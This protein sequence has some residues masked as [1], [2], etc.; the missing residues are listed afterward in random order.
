M[1]KARMWFLLD[2]LLHDPTTQVRRQMQ[3]EAR[4]V[5]GLDGVHVVGRMLQRLWMYDTFQLLQSLIDHEAA[6]EDLKEQLEAV[7]ACILERG[8][9]EESGVMS[10]IKEGLLIV[11]T[12]CDASVRR[13][14]LMACRSLADTMDLLDSANFAPF[15][16]AP[17]TAGTALRIKLRGGTRVLF[18]TDA[19]R[20][21]TDCPCCG[22]MGGFLVSHLFRDCTAF[23]EARVTAMVAVHKRMGVLGVKTAPWGGSAVSAD[24]AASDGEPVDEKEKRML[25]YRL[26]VGASVP[27]DFV[28]LDLE[29][30]THHA[31]SRKERYCKRQAHQIDA[32]A[33]V[34]E[35]SYPFLKQVC[36]FT[37]TKLVEDWGGTL[38]E[39]HTDRYIAMAKKKK[40]HV[41]V[42]EVEV[43]HADEGVV[44]GGMVDDGD[45]MKHEDGGKETETDDENGEDC[46]LGVDEWVEWEEEGAHGGAGRSEEW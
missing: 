8:D 36:E 9:W 5:L 42:G 46:H 2:T 1:T 29:R 35:L 30:E 28:D 6:T 15:L 40:K 32:Y 21:V 25:W 3:A 16:A 4:H 18:S 10:E 22:Q 27:A 43:V 7:R 39:T 14:A 45:A 33:E 20:E 12:A 34:L 11:F 13:A 23:S 24:S 44:A 41:K 37:R 38:Y 17:R 26:F 19:F 31:R